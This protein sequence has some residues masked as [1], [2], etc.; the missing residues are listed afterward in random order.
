VEGVA[1]QIEA[2]QRA[3]LRDRPRV[4]SADVVVVGGEA[5][6]RCVAFFIRGTRVKIRKK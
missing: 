2:L 4:L 1:V 5:Q 6:A 3:V